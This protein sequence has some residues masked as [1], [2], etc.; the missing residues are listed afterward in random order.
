MPQLSPQKRSQLTSWLREFSSEFAQTAKGAHHA[1]Q[2]AASRKS[3]RAFFDEAR[4]RVASG[5]DATDYIL[6]HLLP[7]ANT[8]PNRSRDVW[9][10]I[11]PCVTRDLKEWFE[12]AAWARRE[13]WPAIARLLFEFFDSSERDPARIAQWCERFRENPL[14]KGFRAAF[15]SPMLNA[16]RPELFAIVN[17]KPLRLLSWCYDEKFTPSIRRYPA[18]SDMLRELAQDLR[19]EL[20]RAGASNQDPHDTLDMFA[21]WLVSTKRLEDDG[22]EAEGETATLESAVAESPPQSEKLWLLAA[23]RGG[24]DWPLFQS[25]QCI[26][27]DYS[28]TDDLRGYP[29]REAMTEALR[30][31]ATEESD[32]DPTNHSLAC[33]EF[34]RA[35]KP[36]DMVMAKAGTSKILG[37]GIVT[38]EYR[39]VPKAPA[40]KHRRDVRWLKTGS[41]QVP[42]SN[43]PKKTLTKVVDPE[44]RAALEKAISVTNTSA[45]DV[46]GTGRYWWMNFNPSFWDV[47]AKPDGWRE[48]YTTHNQNGRPRYQPDAF[49]AA[50][51]GDLVLGYST[52][53]R[54]RVAVLC[55]VTRARHESAEG[56]AIE[57]ERVRALKRAVSREEL[58]GDPRL[59]QLGA[60]RNPQGSLFPVAPAEFDAIMELA[61]GEEAAVSPYTIE[62]A[63]AELFMPPEKI[64]DA[65]ALLKD[66]LNLVLQGPPG[67]GKTFAARRLGSLLLGAEDASRMEIV[68]FHP[69]TSYEDFVLGLRPDGQGRFVLKPGVFHRFCRRAQADVSRPYVFIIDEINRGN[70]ARIFGELMLLLEGDKRGERH[71]VPLAYS[72][73]ADER[74][75]LP[76]NLHVIGTMNTADRSLALVDYALRRRFAFVTLEPDFG[77]AFRAE[78]ARNK[79]SPDV[80]EKIC[81][82]MGEL[83][84]AISAETRSLGR[85]YQ[86]GHSFFC[87]RNGIADSEIWYR[88]IVSHELQP[89]LEE[90]WIDEPNRAATEVAK[91]LA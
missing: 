39:F 86:I 8:A 25:E 84:A 81:R 46:Q 27:V 82:R 57:F 33:W 14:S 52:T 35:M 77:A 90:Y 26:A 70:L 45:A 89:L 31:L 72:G 20:E 30:T 9:M 78:L 32:S 91:L 66:R 79:R 58:I 41:W 34:S 3:G 1:A 36:G 75:Y 6:S 38:G 73:D 49:A 88:K 87:A 65:L 16:L 60:L 7:H 42:E 56:Q 29:S 12:G 83:N 19:Q 47:E 69:S 2:Y 64:N 85:G 11:A 23:G 62:Q 10:H 63:T 76:P 17:K 67:V 51:P 22:D 40:Y 80:V 71:A 43:L 54:K 61:E 15:L 53:P 68:Q 24:K 37:V 59:E 5:K 18:I 21:H 44:F 48:P 74:F 50:Q 28:G 55:R 13:D 4:Q